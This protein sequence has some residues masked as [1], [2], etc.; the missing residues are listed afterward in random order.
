V[1]RADTASQRPF[2]SRVVRLEARDGDGLGG[3]LQETR[4]STRAPSG[5]R[6]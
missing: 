6:Q 2:C 5:L 4:P 1:T 3:L